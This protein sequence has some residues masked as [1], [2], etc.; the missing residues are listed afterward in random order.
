MHSVPTTIW[1]Q[2]GACRIV[3]TGGIAT[4]STHP[5]K[6]I[7]TGEGGMLTNSDRYASLRRTRNHGMVR[8]PTRFLNKSMSFEG[9]DPAP[10]YYEM[11]APAST[12]VSISMPLLAS[13]SWETRQF[14]GKTTCSSGAVSEQLDRSARMWPC[15]KSPKD[16]IQPGILPWP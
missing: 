1:R 13:A 14:R 5:V 3:S 2:H 12:T 7:A 8:E 4:F 16:A 15:R 6:T 10:W 11:H 9:D